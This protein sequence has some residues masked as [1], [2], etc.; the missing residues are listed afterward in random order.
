MINRLFESIS[1]ANLTSSLSNKMFCS[2]SL[3]LTEI[4]SK[5][6][7]VVLQ[8]RFDRNNLKQFLTKNGPTCHF[9]QLS[10]KKIYKTK[11]LIL[12]EM[13]HNS[14]NCVFIEFFLQNKTNSNRHLIERWTL[15]TDVSTEHKDSFFMSEK[16][17]GKVSI[18]VRS[19]LCMLC[20]TP[21]W[22]LYLTKTSQ[23]QNFIKKTIL[24]Y[25]IFFEAKNKSG[26]DQISQKIIKKN[27]NLEI[28]PE[29]SINL[30]LEYLQDFNTMMEA[31]NSKMGIE[32]KGFKRLRFLSEGFPYNLESNMKSDISTNDSN[33]N[34]TSGILR[35]DSDN[36]CNNEKEKQEKHQN[37]AKYFIYLNILKQNK[38]KKGN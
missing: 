1:T 3:F 30:N 35:C 34:N 19:L 13:D 4:F 15:W 12:S 27:I 21:I 2:F 25:N 11:E 6:S 7:E 18:F 32:E 37:K 24:D 31:Q 14:K 16:I 36:F 20:T 29:F 28:S 8:M 26:F 22:K 38:K 5:I 33:A 9:F 23:S 10:L 17:I